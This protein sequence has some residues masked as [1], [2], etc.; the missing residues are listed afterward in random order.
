MNF[1]FHLAKVSLKEEFS[2][3]LWPRT[4][5]SSSTL[6]SPPSPPLLCSSSTRCLRWVL[7]FLPFLRP[8]S[9]FLSP[10][11]PFFPSFHATFPSFSPSLSNLP[12]PFCF[13]N[14]SFF[15]CP[16]KKIFSST[17]SS[18]FCL[19]CR[20]F[21]FPSSFPLT[22]NTFCSFS[23]EILTSFCVLSFCSFSCVFFCFSFQSCCH[24][25]RWNPLNQRRIRWKQATFEQY[26]RCLWRWGGFRC[27]VSGDSQ[28]S[29]W[30]WVHRGVW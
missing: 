7:I 25:N 16:L 26:S 2:S 15:S 24:F 17:Y 21:C 19:F 13:L 10:S 9:P 1:C 20:L 29:L 18:F 30:V 28:V 23:F 8:I 12:S 14:L 5:L 27:E 4:R 6:S 11:P 3:S 22:L